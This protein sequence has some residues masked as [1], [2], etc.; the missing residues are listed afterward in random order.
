ME[1]SV[2]LTNDV[3]R[4]IGQFLARHFGENPASLDVFIKPPFTLIPSRDF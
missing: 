3:A 4:F 1:E 2:D